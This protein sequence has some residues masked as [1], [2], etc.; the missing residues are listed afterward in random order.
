M[1]HTIGSQGAMYRVGL[2]AQRSIPAHANTAAVVRCVIDEARLREIHPLAKIEDTLK[3]EHLPK[4]EPGLKGYVSVRGDV[5]GRAG[6]A[7]K[8]GG[9]AG[10]LEHAVAIDRGTA[11]K[12]TIRGPNR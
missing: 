5:D 9:R 8:V 12:R 7:D 1:V 4:A 10:Q 6:Q 11:Q 3:A 2:R